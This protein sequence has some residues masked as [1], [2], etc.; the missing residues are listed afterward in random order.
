MQSMTGYAKS[1]IRYKNLVLEC[2]IK[3]YNHRFLQT[4]LTLHPE[5]EQ[6]DYFIEKL[7]RENIKRGYIVLQIHVLKSNSEPVI[8]NGFKLKGLQA[9]L[10][11]FKKEFKD[12]LLFTLGDFMDLCNKYYSS[13]SFPFKFVKKLLLNC[14]QELHKTRL[15]EGSKI[16]KV[17]MDKIKGMKMLVDE[18]EKKIPSFQ[19][20]YKAKL[21]NVMENSS[22]NESTVANRE[23]MQLVQG[24]MVTEEIDRTK[25]HLN[26]LG[27]LMN[28]TGNIGKKV[29]FV[30][31]ELARETNTLS[32]KIS[33]ANIQYSCVQMRD[34]LEE[35]REQAENIE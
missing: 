32:A 33:S 17:F 15:S 25:F 19:A 22:K 2:E 6:Y 20:E 26:T 14:F 21:T 35:L 16:K 29:T 9:Q 11:E 34:L 7:I 30:L 27:D 8:F 28:K 31:Q 18:V 10:L 3:S 12:N 23:L 5:I 13:S 1:G 24:I 4:R